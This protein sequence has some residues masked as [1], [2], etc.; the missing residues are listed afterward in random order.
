M[1]PSP[2]PESA[3]SQLKACLEC[4]CT[5]EIPCGYCARTQKA[6][7]YAAKPVRTPLTRKNLDA[8]E[9]K[10][11][12]LTSLLK[13]LNPDVDIEALLK[14]GVA[15]TSS[16][17]PNN[18]SPKSP[19][20]VDEASPGSSHEY[21]WH[22]APLS[23]DDEQVHSLR[24]GMALLSTDTSESGYLGSSAGSSMLQTICSLLSLRNPLDDSSKNEL[25]AIISKRHRSDSGVLMLEGDLASS[26]VTDG[27][28]DAYFLLYNTSY[29]VLHS[30]LFRETYANRS[31]IAS[32]SAWQ[33]I[34]YTVLAIGHWVLSSSDDHADSPYYLAARSR[35]SAGMLESGTLAGVQAFLL[36]GNYLQKRDRPNTGY[37]MI[38]I[39]FRMALGLGLH[40]EIASAEGEQNTLNKEIRRRIWWILYMVDSGFSITMGRP[41][42]ASDAFIDVRLPQNIEDS[43]LT[44]D[45]VAL[46]LPPP[47]DYPTS[48]SAM[49]AQAQLAIIANKIYNE[50]LAAH[51]SNAVISEELA[52]KFE[53]ELR[54]WKKSLPE[55]FFED[56][57]PTW[58]L[59]A[60]AV[61]LWKE[62]NLRMIL[63]RG[64]QRSYKT[65]SRSEL[66]VQKC[67]H[68]AI[69]TVQ[70][71]CN[72]CTSN[73]R[74]HQGLSWYAIYFLFQAVLVL[75]V[76]L[77]QAP[78]DALATT[79]RSV[80]DQARQCLSQLGGTSAAAL[81]C[82]S[83][84][85]RI[86]THH[87]SVASSNQRQATNDPGADVFDKFGDAG[88]QNGHL[89]YSIHQSFTADPALQFFLDGQP[90]TNLFEGV[91]GFPSTQEEQ[92]FDYIPGDFYNIEDFD[93][94]MNWQNNTF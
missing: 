54:L 75:D 32:T 6:C 60:K 73:G 83:V 5:G 58:F 40:R 84:L 67:M 22:E 3:A 20:Q 57:I 26:F 25:S 59:G 10:C 89:D 92:N 39:A 34:F 65:G 70:V 24:D 36:M 7:V 21:E 44:S 94:S 71:I 86:H 56:E 77:L 1:S 78:E 50:F 4:Q 16:Q 12:K 55:Y 69:E 90:M 48:Y 14:N 13:S 52:H 74:L 81:R 42:T 23:N 29:P 51:I 17:P 45:E 64:G 88:L 8:A 62:Q 33:L 87:I 80:I 11:Q 30:Q 38:G 53:E 2:T 49:I 43:H 27:L 47:V 9:Q 79:W 63:W 35:M 19:Q 61:L 76:G 18:P 31:Q 66:A 41:T 93:T 82:I 15:S 85:N 68:V 28:I 46:P 72:F 37:N 91:S